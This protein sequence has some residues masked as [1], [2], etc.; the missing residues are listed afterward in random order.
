MLFIRFDNLFNW[1]ETNL[2]NHMYFSHNSQN[3]VKHYF[4]S[5]VH[6]NG[7]LHMVLEVLTSETMKVSWFPLKTEAHKA[8][9]LSSHFGSFLFL[10]TGTRFFPHL[11]RA[12]PVRLHCLSI[13]LELVL[14]GFPVLLA[15]PSGI[16]QAILQH[17]HCKNETMKRI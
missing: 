9:H 7:L 15:Q 2:E 4:F 16:L 8:E 10:Q 3:S 11:L 13:V 14:S 12:W 1:T 17:S 5:G 6:M